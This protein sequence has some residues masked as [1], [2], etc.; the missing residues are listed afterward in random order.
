MA[1]L[2]T[3]DESLDTHRMK[4]EIYDGIA[5]VV[6]TLSTFDE[7]LDTHRMKNEIYEVIAFVVL[8]ALKRTVILSLFGREKRNSPYA[9]F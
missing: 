5:F 9:N 6:A 8:W 4:N 3:F 7:S 1:T 2:S